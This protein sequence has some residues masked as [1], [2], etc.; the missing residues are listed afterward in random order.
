M[1]KGYGSIICADLT[2]KK[3]SYGCMDEDTARKFIGGVGFAAKILW[4]K[5]T[6]NT[7]PLSPE[8][9]L[10]F[11][12]GPLTGSVVPKS[13]RYIIAAISPLTGIWGQAH[14]GGSWAMSS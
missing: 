11:M 9:P 4:D 14:S 5:T 8:N 3:I 13:S 12:T 7:E 6:G 10:I 2:T 1:L